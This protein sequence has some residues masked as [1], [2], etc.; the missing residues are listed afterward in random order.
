MGL[1]AGAP[2]TP[3]GGGAPPLRAAA[4]TAAAGDVPLPAL[5]AAMFRENLPPSILRPIVENVAAEL[6]GRKGREPL[7][8]LQARVSAAAP[9]RD[10]LGALRSGFGV[11]AEIKRKSPSIG[12]MLHDNVAAIAAVYARSPVVRAVSV[13]TNARD[14]GMDLPELARVRA[15]VPQPLLRKDFIFDPYQV[16]QARASGADAILLMANVVTREGLAELSALAESLGLSV[17]FE[18][19]TAEEIGKLPPGA[20]ICGIN[21]RRFLARTG[22][23]AACARWVSGLLK[24]AGWVWDS[25]IDRRPFALVEQLPAGCVR[26]AESGLD[27]SM[28]GLIRDELRF[29]AVLVG[30]SILMSRRGVEAALRSFENAIAASPAAT[31]AP[32]A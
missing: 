4:L 28:M 23:R 11:I 10:F 30:T 22:A 16:W 8:E 6:A 3:E 5:L 20:K 2:R 19:H 29:D 21:S 17:L 26:V 25:S 24:K 27:A 1:A 14:F 12:P 31:A 9:T 32:P 7:A 15:L 18:V 13:L